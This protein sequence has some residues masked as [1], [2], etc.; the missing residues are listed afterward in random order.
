[1]IDPRDQTY[2]DAQTDP[3]LKQTVACA[4]AR[5]RRPDRLCVGDGVPPLELPRLDGTGSVR[6]DGFS[7]ARPLT[8]IF[9]SYT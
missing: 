7:P 2:I 1:V 3:D 4:L 5:Y 9:G 6:L 8:L